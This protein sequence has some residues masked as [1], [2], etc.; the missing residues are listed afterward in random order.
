MD[1]I[2]M[3]FF[4]TYNLGR[5]RVLIEIDETLMIVVTPWAQK[6]RLPCRSID[7]RCSLKA[8][9]FRQDTA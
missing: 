2:S 7:E 3:R 9:L 4:L 1:A 6:A 8:R 5:A